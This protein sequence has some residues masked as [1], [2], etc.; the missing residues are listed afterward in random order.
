[1][2]QK[3]KQIRNF[4]ALTFTATEKLYMQLPSLGE[5]GELLDE[6]RLL[7]KSQIFISAVTKENSQVFKNL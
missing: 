3:H 4:S 2:A 1:M 6:G 5:E 7:T